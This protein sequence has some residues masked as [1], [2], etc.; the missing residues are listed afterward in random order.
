METDHFLQRLEN[1]DKFRFHIESETGILHSSAWFAREAAGSLYI[2]PKGLGAA[3]KLSLHPKG[4]SRDGLDTQFG[5][6]P[7]EARRQRAGG[8]SPPQPLR[9]K[10]TPP[11]SNGATQIASIIF[12]SDYLQTPA[13]HISAR[14]KLKFA[15]PM[16]PFGHAIEVGI[17][18]TLLS[19]LPLEE[20]FLR[21]GFTPMVCFELANS[22][23]A[24]LAARQTDLA[25]WGSIVQP[26]TDGRP[27][28]L[29]GMPEKG[30]QV[31]ARCLVFSAP[32]EEGGIFLIAELGAVTF[33]S[34]GRT[35]RA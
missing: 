29:N 30:E 3:M 33:R 11:P 5:L 23:A 14:S 18:T 9:W 7:D 20:N 19:P 28:P 16:P 10:R 8:F 22:E 4:T 25:R 1:L 17:F 6:T 24:I 26:P 35:D 31:E 12:P 34:F 13:E 32:P 15:L 21:L 27:T 2:A